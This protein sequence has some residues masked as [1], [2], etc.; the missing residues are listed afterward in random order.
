MKSEKTTI[1][2]SN[3]EYTL[4]SIARI[5]SEIERNP[6]ASYEE[7]HEWLNKPVSEEYDMHV[8]VPLTAVIEIADAIRRGEKRSKAALRKD[9]EAYAAMK[10]VKAKPVQK[11]KLPA[12]LDMP[13]PGLNLE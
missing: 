9:R 2:D 1:M 8:T 4:E 11:F 13:K 6:A 7:L 10:I 3:H 5:E 12:Q